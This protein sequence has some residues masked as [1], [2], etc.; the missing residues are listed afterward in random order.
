M[1]Y[2]YVIK[3][4]KHKFRYVGITNNIDERIGRHNAGRNSSTKPYAPF[5]L[6]LKEVYDNYESAR[7]REKFLKSG[8]GRQLLNSLE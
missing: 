2:L 8:V 3:S 5:T 7:Q 4:T 6:V 1:I